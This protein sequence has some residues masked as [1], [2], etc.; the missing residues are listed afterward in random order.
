MGG[1]FDV[2]EVRAGRMADPQILPGDVVVVGF[3]QAR[4]LYRDALQILP[5]VMGAFV[6]LSAYSGNNSN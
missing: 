2:T 5:S 1:R 6:T 4:A 3:S